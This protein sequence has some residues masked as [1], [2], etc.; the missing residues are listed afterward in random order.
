MRINPYLSNAELLRESWRVLHQQHL[1]DLQNLNC[2]KQQS[3]KTQ[4]DHK[5]WVSA[6]HVDVM[7]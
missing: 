6:A 7:V 1:E 2:Q 5:Q 4:Q 3:D